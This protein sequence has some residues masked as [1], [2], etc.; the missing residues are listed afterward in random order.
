MSQQERDALRTRIRSALPIDDLLGW[1]VREFPDADLER[2]LGMMRL[3]HEGFDVRPTA[4]AQR[5][6]VVGGRELEA[7]PER[8]VAV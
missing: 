2:V 5:R 1:L 6:Y 3:V 8:I 4:H 7:S